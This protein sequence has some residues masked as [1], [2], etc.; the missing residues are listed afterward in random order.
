MVK[1]GCLEGVDEVYGLHNIPNHF[2]GDIR[3]IPGPIFAGCTDM[4]FEVIG[5]GGHGSVPHK[6]ID[7][8][9]CAC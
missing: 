5:Q 3:V 7:P 8:M 9:T 2:E 1:E 4:T 6:L